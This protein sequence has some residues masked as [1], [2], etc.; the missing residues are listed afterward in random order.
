MVT[1]RGNIMT[2][3]LSNQQKNELTDVELRQNLKGGNLNALKHGLLTQESLL[4]G[5]DAK[6]LSELKE[7]FVRDL[8]P[9]DALGGFLIDRVVSGIW[10]LKRVLRVEN[11]LFRIYCKDKEMPF[12]EPPKEKIEEKMGRAFITDSYG[13]KGFEKL[14]RYE[15]SIERGIF[16]ALNKLEEL[17]KKEGGTL[18]P[19]QE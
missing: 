11:E 2:E 1:A 3:D 10:R 14:I 19:N 5:E 9:S 16:R 8:A 7:S 15:V 12:I 17:R 18:K 4:P 6:K 13:S